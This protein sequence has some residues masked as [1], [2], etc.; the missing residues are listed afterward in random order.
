MEKIRLGIIG[1]GGMGFHHARSLSKMKD[2]E[3][4]AASDINPDNLKQFTEEFKTKHSFLDYTQILNIEEIEGVLICLPTFLHREVV[5]RSAAKGKHI[6]CEK[7][8]AMNLRDA[9]EMIKACQKN[10]VKFM[11]G[12]VRRFDNFWGKARE[13]IKGGLLGRPVIWHNIASSSGAPHS[14]YFDKEKGG[15]P[16]IDG[17]V[18]NYDFGH[19]TFG[20]VKRVFATTMRFK[21][22]ISAIDTGSAIIKYESGDEHIISW[23]WGLPRGAFGARVTDIIGPRGGLLFPD[24]FNE[25]EI[26]Q[27]IDQERY[28]VFLLSL[29]GEKKEWIKW[30]KNDMFF[31]ELLHFVDCIREDREP[32]VTG[33]DGK[34]ALEVGLAVLKSGE[35]GSPVE[36]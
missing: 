23:S 15:G 12:F 13:I 34:K 6:F 18:H 1:C 9:D 3:I 22:S 14:W 20:R 30:E 31:D 27:S 5:I 25:K 4:M 26:P 7:P 29:K 36:I 16:L 32:C 33:E 35:T 17:A 2:V 10:R 28:G 24:C 8:I 21:E 11:M 19:Y